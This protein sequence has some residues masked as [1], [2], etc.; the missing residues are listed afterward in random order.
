MKTRTAA[1]L[2]R[3]V[4]MYNNI[5]LGSVT[6]SQWLWAIHQWQRNRSHKYATDFKVNITEGDYSLKYVSESFALKCIKISTQRSFLG[7]L[8]MTI[9]GSK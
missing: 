8:A 1:S 4:M 9:Q 2:V 3:A 6:R 5:Q 7:L